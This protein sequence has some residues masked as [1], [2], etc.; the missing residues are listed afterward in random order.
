[1][2]CQTHKQEVGVST[3][4]DGGLTFGHG[5]LD[6]LGYWEINCIEAERSYRRKEA[7]EKR[8]R[9]EQFSK[10]LAKW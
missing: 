5:E 10:W 9:D 1:M 4:I 6:H 3:G 8:F 2:V 7:A